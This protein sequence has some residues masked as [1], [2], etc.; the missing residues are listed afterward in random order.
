MQTQICIALDCRATIGSKELH[1]EQVNAPSK[2][3]IDR[4]FTGLFSWKKWNVD[5]LLSSFYF[6]KKRKEHDNDR[7]RKNRSNRFMARK[8]EKNQLH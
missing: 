6:L 4:I 7:A 8:S 2:T 5:P 1:Q 3:F